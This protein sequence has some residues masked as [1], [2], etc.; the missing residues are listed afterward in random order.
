MQSHPMPRNASQ[1]SNSSQEQS[2]LGQEKIRRVAGA[3][4]HDARQALRLSRSRR[5]GGATLPAHDTSLAARYAR[6]IATYRHADL[7]VALGQIDSLIQASRTIP[8]SMS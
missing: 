8:I 2:Q 3:A 4:R 1:P 5:Y 7:R 6:A